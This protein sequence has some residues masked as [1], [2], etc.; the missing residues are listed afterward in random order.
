MTGGEFEERVD[1]DIQQHFNALHPMVDFH[2][3][4]ACMRF[5]ADSKKPT[6]EALFEHCNSYLGKLHLECLHPQS[7]GLHLGEDAVNLFTAQ[8]MLGLQFNPTEHLQEGVFELVGQHHPEEEQHTVYQRYLTFKDQLEAR[9]Y[10]VDHLNAYPSSI[11][12]MRVL[13]KALQDHPPNSP[14]HIP[15][16]GYTG[17]HPESREEEDRNSSEDSFLHHF[18]GQARLK[19]FLVTCLSTIPTG[20]NVN[21]RSSQHLQNRERFLISLLHGV[22]MNMAFG[23]AY[24]R[25]VLDE[26][27]EALRLKVDWFMRDCAKNLAALKAGR[28]KTPQQYTETPRFPGLI[29]VDQSVEGIRVA[30]QKHQA[31]EVSTFKQLHGPEASEEGLLLVRQNA[32][33]VHL[34]EHKQLPLLKVLKDITRENLVDGVAAFYSSEAGPGPAHSN[35]AQNLSHGSHQTP[36]SKTHALGT[37]SALLSLTFGLLHSITYGSG[38]PVCFVSGPFGYSSPESSSSRVPR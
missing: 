21:W 19:I 37:A 13:Q 25:G 10:L 15:Y 12:K 18:V 28:V 23:G 31:S 17:R 35:Y 3:G 11:V 26:E 32:T 36:R 38:W 24:P 30:Y 29:P 22:T 34:N 20:Q 2:V 6:V 5:V 33:N 27:T 7:L 8:A 1:M 9:Q 14:V 4:L 16:V